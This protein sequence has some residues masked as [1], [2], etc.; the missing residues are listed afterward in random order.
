MSSCKKT[1]E[2]K[3]K[4]IYNDPHKYYALLEKSN[5]DVKRLFF[6]IKSEKKVMIVES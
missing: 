5:N 1:V 6:E 3:S 4:D 2:K